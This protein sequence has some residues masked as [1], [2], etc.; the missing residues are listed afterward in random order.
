MNKMKKIQTIEAV[1]HINLMKQLIKVTQRRLNVA[2][3]ILL[4][5]WPCGSHLRLNNNYFPT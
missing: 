5:L 4:S 1:R 3:F 2:Q